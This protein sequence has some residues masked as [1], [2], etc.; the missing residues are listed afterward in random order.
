[1]RKLNPYAVTRRGTGSRERDSNPCLGIA[2]NPW[3][4]IARFLDTDELA[5]LRRSLDARETEWPEA[6]AAIRLTL[7]GCRQSKVLNLLGRDIGDDMIQ[8][9]GSKTG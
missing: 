3:K 6:V 7:T 2:R 5:R 9:G 8:L 1:M 4:Q